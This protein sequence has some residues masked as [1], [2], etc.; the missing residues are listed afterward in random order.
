[1]LELVWVYNGFGC[2]FVFVWWVLF[3]WFLLCLGLVL[4]ISLV[5]VGFVVRVCGYACVWCCV[6]LCCFAVLWA[7]LILVGG[8]RLCHVLF[9]V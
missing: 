6:V 9:V 8:L 5:W 3:C 4:L 7:V 1:M 2:A